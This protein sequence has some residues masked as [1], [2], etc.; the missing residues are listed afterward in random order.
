MSQPSTLDNKEL[1]YYEALAKEWWDKDGKFWPLHQLN[2][3]REAYLKQQICQH[4]GR[5]V[6]AN[7]CLQGL[8]VIDVGCG[9]GILSESMAMLGAAVTGVDVVPKSLQV[10]RQHSQ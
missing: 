3:V 8:S 2:Q 9:G 4:F 1:S 6:A 10:A 7:H 5:D